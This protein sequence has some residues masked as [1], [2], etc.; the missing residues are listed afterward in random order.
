MVS[1]AVNRSRAGRDCPVTDWTPHD[2]RR[3]M[4]TGLARLGVSHE[5]AELCLGHRLGGVAGV[6]NLYQYAG[7]QRAALAL[8]G[9]HLLSLTA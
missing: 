5:V 7:E 8:W 6:Y 1:N 3:T 2:L 4:R 9:E